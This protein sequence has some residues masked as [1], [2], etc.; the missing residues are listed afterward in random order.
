MH[1]RSQLSTFLFSSLLLSPALLQADVKLTLSSAPAYALKHNPDL[2]AAR[3][4]IAE[5]QARLTQSGRLSNP[6][7]EFDYSKNP[8][9]SERNVGVAFN[10][11]FPLTARLSQEKTLS[12]HQLAQAE[13]EVRNEERK[14]VAE[15]HAASIKLMMADQKKALLE[16]Q[17]QSTASL[18]ETVEKRTQAGEIAPTDAAQLAIDNQNRILEAQQILAQKAALQGELKPLLGISTEVDLTLKG[19]L[20]PVASASKGLNVSGR[21]D[22]ESSRIGESV[23][24]SEIDLARSSR[25]EDVGVGLT[26]EHERSEDAPEGIRGDGYVGFRISL[27]LPF[28]KNQKGLIT[29]KEAA[30]QRAVLETKAL[31]AR[32][33]GEAAA[34]RAEMAAHAKLI[35][36]VNSN[37]LPTIAKHSETI[38]KAYSK[39][40]ADLMSLLK[41]REQ[42][43]HAEST[44]LEA[45][46][47]YHL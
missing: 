8:R 12:R 24:Q 46:R 25:W 16:S 34:A 40:E 7:V 38:E 1:L 44:A 39:G 35:S 41:S 42:K 22:L 15:V 9:S 10:Q 23:A 21:P 3:L 19:A 31:E 45:L 20:P 17:V 2:A 11:K 5:A 4:R 33:K 28:W 43:F 26:F 6:E 14:L 30:Q 36:E 27:P 13:A 18:V 32:I 47:D 37:L 29:E